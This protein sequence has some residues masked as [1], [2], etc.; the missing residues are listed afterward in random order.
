MAGVEA[1]AVMQGA[2]AGAATHLSGPRRANAIAAYAL[3][4][5]CKGSESLWVNAV[6]DVV[7]TAAPH[8][9]ASELAPAFAW[10][11]KSACWSS[12][13]EPHRQRV[14]LLEAIG[15]RDAAAIA[16]LSTRLLEAPG[17]G[18]R[19]RAYLLV[20]AVAAW[21]ALGNKAQ[22]RELVKRHGSAIPARER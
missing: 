5:G 21:T 9:A 12:L 11:R 18:E 17:V 22:A 2:S 3:A 13:D 10:V 15:A 7:H 1:L 16:Q 4:S 6:T 8:L 14:A 20:N 19:E